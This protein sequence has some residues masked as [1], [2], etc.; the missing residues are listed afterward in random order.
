MFVG[1]E[2]V[3]FTVPYVGRGAPSTAIASLFEFILFE[4]ARRVGLDANGT[5]AA[6]HTSRMHF[7]L[8]KLQI[9]LNLGPSRGISWIFTFNDYFTRT[10]RNNGKQL[11]TRR[12]DALLQVTFSATGTIACG[13]GNSCKALASGPW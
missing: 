3:S 8:T 5:Y 13:K 11:Q 4:Q 6:G 1:S 2:A 7:N 10:S 12:S 9:A